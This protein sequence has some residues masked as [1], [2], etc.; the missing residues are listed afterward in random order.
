[1]GFPINPPST[2]LV[3]EDGRTVSNEWNSFFVN[4]QK[5]IGGPVSPFDDVQVLAG[6]SDGLVHSKQDGDPTLDALAALDATPGLLTQTG[7]DAFTKRTLQAPAAG[8]T[9]TNPAGTAADPTFVLANDL[10]ALEALSGTNTIYYRS[11]VDTW[12]AVTVGSALSFSAGTLDRAALTGDITA[13]AGSNATTLATVNANVGSFGSATQVGAFT[14]NAKGLITAASNVTIT[15][16]VGSITGLGTGVATAL[17]VNVG[18]AGAFVTFNGAGGTPS[19]LTLTNAT[20]LPV[21]GLV[22]ASEAQGD[23][24]YRGAANWVRLG[25]GTSGQFLKTQGAAADPVWATLAGGG[26]MLAANNLSDVASAATSRTNLGLAIGTNVQAYDAQLASLAG[27]SYTSNALKVIRVNAGETDFEL[28]SASGSAAWALAGTGQT[29]TGIYDFSVDGAKAN[30]DFVGLASYNELLVI[31]RGLSDG[32]SGVRALY[33]SV[34]NGSTFYQTAGDYVTISTAGVEANTSAM[35][36]HSTSATAARSFVGHV[37]NMK[38]TTKFCHTNNSTTNQILFV[39]SASDINAVRVANSAGGN[40]T[41]G[42][43]HVY[44]R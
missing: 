4:I 21:A 39:A 44:A 31:A 17:G 12:S 38:G 28:A 27:L 26:D 25:A 23:I 18:S 13:S 29:A 35:A 36:F 20:G 30:I 40:I 6:G 42:T 37:V 15:P 10:A 34:D 7:A 11:G 9:I 14:V 41:A 1:M 19:S 5:V 33:V 16:A 43:V 8:L 24:I 32:T 3:K 22:A 2:P